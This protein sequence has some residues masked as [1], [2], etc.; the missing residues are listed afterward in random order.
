MA[1]DLLSVANLRCEAEINPLGIDVSR[2]RLSWKYRPSD[3]GRT[4]AAF[5]VL[6]YSRLED[7]KSD[8]EANL[9]SSGRIASKSTI[10]VVYDGKPLASAQCAYWMVRA[11]DA[12]GETIAPTEPGYW[13][14]GLLN[15]TDWKA[16][17][18]AAL[19]PTGLRIDSGHLRSEFAC[20]QPIRRARLYA[21][22][23]GIY[24][25]F[26][27]GQR[28]GESYFRPGWT[29][30]NKRIQYQTYD[31]T[32]LLKQGANAIGFI[33]GDGWFCGELGWKGERNLYGKT[34]QLMAQLEIEFTDG[35]TEQI[36]TDG[37]WKVAAGPILSSD[38]LMG[39]TYDAR[40]EMTG[41]ATPEFDDRGW[42]DAKEGTAPSAMLVSQTGPPVQKLR[43]LRP[44][45]VTP[46]AGGT[47]VF[48]LG[49]NMVGWARLRVRGPAGSTVILR[50]AEMLNRDGSLYTDNLR[51]ARS[52]DQY[53][54]KG[55]REEIYE[56]SFTFHGFRY[57]EI[58]GF[59]GE[60]TLDTITGIVVGSNLPSSG[61]FECS[62]PL[63]NQLLSNIVWGQRG[64]FLEVPTD[65]PQRDERLGWM[66]DAQI[67]LPTATFNMDCSSFIT[68]W[69]QDVLDAQSPEGGFSDVSPRICH[70]ADGAGLGRRG[71]DR[72]VDDLPGLRRSPNSGK[73][74]R[75]DGEMDRIY[76]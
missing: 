46:G 51:R 1:E 75:S 28:I 6:V 48:D 13:E 14:T 63:L 36:I 43:E 12:D 38:F 42:R 58:S 22:A 7:L 30:Y 60:P 4:Q 35:S 71:G 72:S 76:S 70:L 52:V 8:K 11:W 74:F 54:L 19:S 31:V 18:I 10:G 45:T 3:R 39:E 56:P 23:Q 17:W 73:V 27:N 44:K 49:Q 53:T 5:E 59:V 50:F 29:D 68:K 41:W 26:L 37:K 66:A 25:G 32:S 47:Y 20:D 9:W 24:V 57:V 34:P 65:C 55:G 21:S 67:F 62:N 64:N 40:R 15:P 33:L 61:T 69:I 16:S 2:P